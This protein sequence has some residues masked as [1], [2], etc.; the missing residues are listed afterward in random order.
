MKRPALALVT[1]CTLFAAP[2]SG[3]DLKTIS[4]VFG[5]FDSRPLAPATNGIYVGSR[6]GI[7]FVDNVPFASGVGAFDAAYS[8]SMFNAFHVGYRFA[9]LSGPI[10]G[11][12]ELEGGLMNASVDQHTLNGSAIDTADSFGSVRS[13][14]GFANAFA[15]L[16]LGAAMQAPPDSY[17]NRLTP[18][19][20]A[21]FG[22][23]NVSLLRSGVS[24]TGV[25]MDGSST[26]PV[27][28]L[29]GGISMEVVEKTTFEIGYRFQQVMG[30]EFTAR[31]GTTSK[32]DLTTNVVTFGLRRQ[33]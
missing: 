17:L 29:S 10:G 5:I 6:N 4:P 14:F 11:R 21:G 19:V 31:E 26:K 7:A 15:D 16:N 27:F 24:S 3:A 32:T 1:F 28:Q 9:S 8:P 25:V 23:A 12:V 13:I 30:L 22:M 33:F 20:G 18:F 2:T